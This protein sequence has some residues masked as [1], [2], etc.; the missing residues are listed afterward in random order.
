[1]WSEVKG[2]RHERFYSGIWEKII[3]F[4]DVI[5]V[6]SV[7]LVLYCYSKWYKIYFGSCDLK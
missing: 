5:K 3:N 7:N 1:M 6:K 2:R 4:I